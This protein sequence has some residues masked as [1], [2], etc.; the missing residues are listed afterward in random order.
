MKKAAWV[1]LFCLFVL[2]TVAS[3]QVKTTVSMMNGDTIPCTILTT[4]LN[5]VTDYGE[6]QF[7]VK[8]IS[9]VS[10]P[11]PGKGNTTLKTI[12]GE[13][14]RGF[15]TNEIIRFQAYGAN[16]DIRKA[17]IREISFANVPAT[18][19][20]SL[21]TVSLRNG[22]GFYANPL[23]DSIRLQTSY[24]EVP[25]PF[26]DVQAIHFEGFG[27]VLTKIQ[28]KDG[29][30]IQGIIK[31]DFIPLALLSAKELEIVPDMLKTIQ[32]KRSAIEAASPKE[33]P[34]SGPA[35]SF[36][37]EPSA[38]TGNTL[39]TSLGAE[40]VLV[41][42]GSFQMGN[43]NSD[44]EGN[45]DE[46]PVHIVRFT[47]DF[48]IGKTEVTFDEYVAYCFD[49]LANMPNDR[50]W[51]KGKRPVINVKWFEAVSF[52]NWL[53]QKEGLKVAY[54]KDGNLL[55]R[56]GKVTKDITQ[57]EGYRLPTEAEWEYA[58]RG[59]PGSKG[60]KY[61]GSNTLSEVGWFTG[62][63]GSKTQPVGQK[64]ANELGLHDMSGN[65]W[66]WCHDWKGYYS[67]S[68]L[69]NPVGPDSGSSRVYRGGSWYSSEQF[70]RA[71]S[72]NSGTPAGSY[73]DGVLG[74][75]VVRT[76]F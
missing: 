49:T 40:M 64:K 29:G 51:G 32:F 26:A 62:N 50:G 37:Q 68:G 72:R 7:E 31:E 9:T 21:L 65:V 35:L 8:N 5:L 52:C 58:A 2:A 47:Y 45:S 53:S 74:F 42:R 39:K 66:E 24:S 67:A 25:L 71:A 23:S 4:T 43:V 10:F 11:E 27:N 33:E 41:K 36:G 73:I 30:T 18:Q 13:Y 59:G 48:W 20:T 76:V 28:M 3:A 69:T 70:C 17:K 1:F 56:N 55:D 75:R 34:V 46:K 63:S 60:F 38:P 15:I 61:A 6:F 12:Y 54:D 44:S 19:N 22:D 16:L 14:F 57:V